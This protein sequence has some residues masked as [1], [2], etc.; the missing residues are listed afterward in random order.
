MSRKKAANPG[1][2][3]TSARYAARAVVASS[4]RIGPPSRRAAA[5]RRVVLRGRGDEDRAGQLLEVP[6]RDGRVGVVRGDD[7]A[8]LG[9]LEPAV[10][11]AGRAAQ[12]G[13]VGRPP[14]APDRPAA[15]VEQRQLH[16]VP[17]GR[18]DQRR[19][20]LVEHP[21]RGEEARLLVRV[22]V[23][24]HHLLAVAAGRQVG[25][26]ARVGEQRLEDV[27][28]GGE[29]LARLEQR[30]DVEDRRRRPARALAGRGVRTSVA[31]H[32]AAVNDTMTDGDA[33]TPKRAWIR[34]DRPERREHLAEADAGRP[35]SVSGPA[36]GVE[37]LE[38]APMDLAVLADLER[39]EVEPERRDL[40][41]QLGDLAPGDPRQPVLDERGLDL[42]ELRIELGRVVVVAGSRPGVVG[43][44]DPRP[45]QALGDEPEALAIRLVGEAP[46]ELAIG[47]GQVLGVAGR[48]ASPA[49]AGAGRS[50]P[51]AADTVCMRRRATAS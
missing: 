18:I 11:R 14:A 7:L 10:D 28:G 13:P 4:R 38:G 33:S 50:L 2:S 20:G 47:L 43:Q 40:P 24:E 22:R 32:A 45:A 27:A 5:A 1:S 48:G 35:R 36:P 25:A 17:R 39:G 46:A 31:S 21:G 44:G 30:H 34:G 3:W 29:G 6:P 37:R 15:T 19:L 41:A 9:Q 42:G 8:L 49:A 23:A 26:V 12:D 51:T 16:A